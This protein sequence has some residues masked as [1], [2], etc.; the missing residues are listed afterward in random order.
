MNVYNKVLYVVGTGLLLTTTIFAT[1]QSAIDIL[2]KAFSYTE[3]MDKYAFTSVIV[4]HEIQEDGSIVPYKYHTSVKVDRPDKLRIDVKS[5]FMDR[6]HYINDGL[7]TLIEHK[8]GKYGQLKV[9]RTIDKALDSLFSHFDV[10]APL[11]SLVYSDMRKRVKFTSSK[12]FGTERLNG[13]ECDYVAF[14]NDVREVHVW[15]STGDF[16][17][18]RTYSITDTSKQPTSKTNTSVTWIKDPKIVDSDFIF[19]VP[20]S[21]VKISILPED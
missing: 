16:P 17:Q 12:Y 21:A 11:A 7:Y 15:I 3:N 8:E 18:I 13:V 19:S 20:K 1:E 4:E 14:N 5:E 2:N 9:P 6:S 10:K